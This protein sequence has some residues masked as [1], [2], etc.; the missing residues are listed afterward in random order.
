MRS[1]GTTASTILF[2][3]ISLFLLY[4]SLAFTCSPSK[5][6]WRAHLTG[7]FF[8]LPLFPSYYPTTN[9]FSNPCSPYI[10][11]GV[12]NGQPISLWAF[13]RCIFFSENWKAGNLFY[14]L[15]WFYWLQITYSGLLM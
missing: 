9:C 10:L 12:M 15:W 4:S 14:T 7:C 6:S 8:V 5:F 11:P 1:T 13:R 3:L 2:L